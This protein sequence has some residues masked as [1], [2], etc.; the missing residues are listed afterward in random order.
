MLVEHIVVVAGLG[1]GMKVDAMWHVPQDITQPCLNP[2]LTGNHSSHHFLPGH[3]PYYL[4][5]NS[6]LLS[7]IFLKLHTLIASATYN[8]DR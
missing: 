5:K 6:T 7:T 8:V 2:T 1:C 4:H 3:T